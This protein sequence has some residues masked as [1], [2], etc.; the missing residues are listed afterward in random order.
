MSTIYCYVWYL[1]LFYILFLSIFRCFEVSKNKN[2]LC[3]YITGILSIFVFFSTYLIFKLLLFM[4]NCQLQ[5]MCI[6]IL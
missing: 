2:T 5:N 3:E 4:C 1:Q 6:L